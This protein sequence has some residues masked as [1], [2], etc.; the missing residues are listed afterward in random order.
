MELIPQVDLRRSVDLPF[1]TRSREA[2]HALLEAATHVCALRREI[3]VIRSNVQGRA[4]ELQ[5]ARQHNAELL[6]WGLSTEKEL[7]QVIT[8]WAQTFRQL[9]VS[10]SAEV[11][12]QDELTRARK[13][14]DA[15]MEDLL[16]SSISR[17]LLE[18]QLKESQVVIVDL[19][20]SLAAERQLVKN[21]Q[22]EIEGV[23]VEAARAFV[24]DFF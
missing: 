21:Q 24:D 11:S 1:Q 20:K 19:S 5:E 7:E 17:T 12:F 13:G 4:A 3:F 18:E 14:Y 9:I 15:Q 8:Q 10:T 23:R 6:S 2:L 22:K 16:D